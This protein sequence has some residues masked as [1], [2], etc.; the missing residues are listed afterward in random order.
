MDRDQ[1]EENPASFLEGEIKEYIAN[2]PNNIM[3]DFPGEHMWDEPL[4]GFA[5]GDDPGCFFGFHGLA[6]YSDFSW[7]GVIGIQEVLT[8]GAQLCE[9]L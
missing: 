9:P 8:C 3:P 7:D 2:S 6:S 4:V 1:T 5:K